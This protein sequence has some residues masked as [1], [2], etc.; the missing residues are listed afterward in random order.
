MILRIFKT[1]QLYIYA[2]IPLLVLVLRWPVFFRDA[3]FTPSGQL[4]FFSDFFAWL[5]IYPWLSVILSAVAISYQ[6][7][8]ISEMM[9]EHRL[10]PYSSNLAAFVLTINYSFLA[11]QAWFSPIILSNIFVVLSLR[12]ILS[13]FHQGKIYGNLFRAGIFIG[14]GSLIY[15]PSSFMLIILIYDLYLIRTFQWREYVIPSLGFIVPYIYLL[16]YYYLRSE[17]DIFLNYFIEPKTFLTFTDYGLFNWL[18]LLAGVLLI[19]SSILYLILS[20]SRRTVRENNLF[21]VIIAMLI[22]TVILCVIYSNDIMSA[23]AL[24]WPAASILIAYFLLGIRRKIISESIG[25]ILII[26]I[27]LRDLIA[28]F[29]E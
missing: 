20:G 26:A 5:S 14:I 16:S 29:T 15:L 25:Y 13:I 2:F 12:R 6:A 1:N 11:P 27:I 24:L 18:P 10:L 17:S 22:I 21:K 4:P 9:N 7:Y 3:P 28:V 8:L 19:C 23:T